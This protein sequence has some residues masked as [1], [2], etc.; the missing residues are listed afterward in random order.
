MICSSISKLLSFCQEIL[1]WA[2]LLEI[3]QSAKSSKKYII[4]RDG[5]LR[6]VYIKQKYLIKIA[7]LA[8]QKG[9]CIVEITKNSSIKLELSS[10]FKKIDEYLET[11]KKPFTLK[12]IL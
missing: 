4:L 2:L 12:N 9:I 7:F 1:E 11:E 3:I 6:S 10:S 5:A 8:K